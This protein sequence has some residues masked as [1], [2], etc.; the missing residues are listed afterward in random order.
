MCKKTMGFYTYT[1]RTKEVNATIRIVIFLGVH[2]PR[3]DVFRIKIK[4]LIR[5]LNILT[6]INSFNNNTQPLTICIQML[7]TII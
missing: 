7:F 2:Q 1:N 3:V 4:H 6:L 5:Y